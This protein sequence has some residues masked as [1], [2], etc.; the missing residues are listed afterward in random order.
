M[1]SQQ[2]LKEG[3]K[4]EKLNAVGIDKQYL[5]SLKEIGKEWKR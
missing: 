3:G 2:E 4:R 1:S 5:D